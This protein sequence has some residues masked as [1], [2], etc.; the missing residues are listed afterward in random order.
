MLT[1]VQAYSPWPDMQT[2]PLS[3][4]GRVE[5]DLIQVRNIDGLD[6]AKA[7]VNTSQFGSIDGASYVGSNVNTRNIVITLHPNPDWVNWTFEN[8]RQLLY[9]YFSPKAKSRLVFYSDNIPPV[10]ISGYVESCESN[11]FSNDPEIIVSIIC[12][13]PH[14]KEV[15]PTVLT[16]AINGDAVPI[17]YEGAGEV[18]LNIQIVSGSGISNPRVQIG[19]YPEFWSEAS[20]Y[21]SEYFQMS[22]VPGQKYARAVTSANGAIRNLKLG[23]NSVWPIFRPGINSFRVAA[24]S[25]SGTWTLTYFKEYTGL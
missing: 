20:V 14:F 23:G 11:I 8:I 6:P 9:T 21:S 4:E 5:T 18:G 3:S 17:L 13:Y 15:S 22:S 1:K 7:V 2:V 16:G 19:L 10:E 12:P 25:G 24:D